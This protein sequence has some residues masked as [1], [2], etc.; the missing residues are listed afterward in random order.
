ME[1]DKN[2]FSLAAACAMSIIYAICAVFVMLFPDF[3][4][5]LLGWLTHLV[6]VDKFA[7]DMAITFGGFIV[8]LI[9]IFVYTYI[10]M[11]IF[12][13]LHNKFKKPSTRETK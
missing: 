2:K 9:Q 5:Q 10:T 8:G 12:A 13:L 1:L 7:G 11:R 3:A 6:N 4:L